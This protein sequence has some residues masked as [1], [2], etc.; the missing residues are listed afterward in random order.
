ML[1]NSGDFSQFSEF[2]YKQIDNLMTIMSLLN[3]SCSK[4][5]FKAIE[6]L[7]YYFMDLE[8]RDDRIIS[9]LLNN[10]VNFEKYFDKLNETNSDEDVIEKKNFILYELEKLKNNEIN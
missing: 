7:H 5:K 10:K 2:Y 9:L 8:S 1:L 4:I 3:H 6:I